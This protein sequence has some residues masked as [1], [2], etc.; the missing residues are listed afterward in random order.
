M[1]LTFLAVLIASTPAVAQD[2]TNECPDPT[3]YKKPRLV[4]KISPQVSVDMEVNLCS[5]VGNREDENGCATHHV[6]VPPEGQPTHQ[7]QLV[8]FLPGVLQ[9]PSQFLMV[10][11]AAAFSGYKTIGLSYRHRIHASDFCPPTGPTVDQCYLDARDEIIYGAAPGLTVFSPNERVAL[12]DSLT[13]RLVSV[14][15]ELYWAD[16]DAD[17]IDQ[18]NW[19]AYLTVPIVDKLVPVPRE[20]TSVHWDKVIIS[21]FSVGTSDVNFLALNHTLDGVLYIDGPVAGTPDLTVFDWDYVTPTCVQTGLY[22]AGRGAD[23]LEIT[24]L[25]DRLGLDAALHDADLPWTGTWPASQMRVF[26]NQEAAPGGCLEPKHGSMA[27]DGCMPTSPTN[28]LPAGAQY[29]R[30]SLFPSLVYLYC[31]VGAINPY[32]CVPYQDEVLRDTGGPRL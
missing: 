6:W 32:T 5:V 17:G 8:V 2:L 31:Q 14:L 3:V 9:R 13:A 15:E 11:S 25:W 24:D 4:G 12:E 16:V 18:H 23:T 30:P 29:G 20:K 28:R 1:W 10:Q 27:R 26:S 19:D 22:H 7:D 21:S